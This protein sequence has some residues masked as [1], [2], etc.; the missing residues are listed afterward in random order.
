MLCPDID[1]RLPVTPTGSKLEAYCSVI[2]LRLVRRPRGE[3]DVKTCE[4][5]NRTPG[6][7]T[8]TQDSAYVVRVCTVTQEP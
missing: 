8:L 5:L 3:V 1:N 7:E 4:L 6:D 2:V